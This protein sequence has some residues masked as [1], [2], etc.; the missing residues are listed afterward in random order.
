MLGADTRSVQT[1]LTVR[2]PEEWSA[3]GAHAP[4]RPRPEDEAGASLELS[5][6]RAKLSSTASTIPDLDN[7]EPEG[8]GSHV[9]GSVSPGPTPVTV[10]TTASGYV[11]APA[12]CALATTST[13]DA[14]GIESCSLLQIG[15]FV[16]VPK[17]HLS[18]FWN[19]DSAAG[20]KA[21]EAFVP[22]GRTGTK[23]PS[24]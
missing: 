20:T 4:K 16:P 6:T 23:C 14:L 21:L 9:S 8:L 19:R 22:G 3:A 17:G 5:W 15:P 24:R 11:P 12:S 18:Q 7:N 10:G 13:T 2:E 1:A